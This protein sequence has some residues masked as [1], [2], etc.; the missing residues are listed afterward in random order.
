M[1]TFVESQA[2]TSLRTVGDA[3]R[4]LRVKGHIGLWP[5]M[6]VLVNLADGVATWLILRDGGREIAPVM[7]VLI[8]ALGLVP[9]MVVKQFAAGIIGWALRR[10][11]GLLAVPTVVLGVVVGLNWGQLAYVWSV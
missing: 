2:R 6:F 4:L 5:I 9:A 10:S 3:A 1:T 7:G 11:P 8:G